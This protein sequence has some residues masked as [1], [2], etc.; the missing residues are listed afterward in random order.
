MADE[1]RQERFLQTLQ[2]TALQNRSPSSSSSDSESQP[3]RTRADLLC[4]Y[5]SMDEMRTLLFIVEYEPPHKLSIGNL[6]AGFRPMNI[7]DIIT[8]ATI[9]TEAEAKL[10]FD[11]DR[12][13]AAV[14]TQ[15]FHYMI[16]NGLEYSY[17][18]TGEVFIF[19]HVKEDD[20]T[21]LYYHVSVPGEEIDDN[22]LEVTLPQTAVS[23][24]MGLCL[25][26]SQSKQRSQRWRT[27]AKKGLDKYRIDYMAILAQIPET[28]RKRSPGSVYKGR[29]PLIYKNSPYYTRLET[30]KAQQPKG[31][32]AASCS[33]EGWRGFYNDEH[34]DP[35]TP[36]R[37]GIGSSRAGNQ[38][39][40]RDRGGMGESTD[41]ST[42]TGTSTG[43]G[44]QRQYCTQDCLL[45]IVRGMPLAERCPN[46]SLH[47]RQ[48]SRHAIDLQGFRSR[49]QNQLAEDLDHD[50]EPLG[51]QG[52]RG[53]LFRITLTSHG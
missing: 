33:P 13:V 26:A 32:G 44:R 39:R 19:L 23:Q 22:E 16:E 5:K 7:K 8:A 15:T 50:C 1:V 2:Q 48:G 30:K 49:V 36:S 47:R 27:T 43:G 41:S 35:G 20:P 9:P 52:A 18:T 45:G 37:P 31:R 10:Q 42:T 3:T 28:E 46:V 6:L 4:V 17:I 38:I 14:A 34:E 11:A 21:T 51:M 29:K 24:V 40:D 25:M 53:A 12:L